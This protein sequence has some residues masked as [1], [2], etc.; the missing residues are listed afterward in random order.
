M[1]TNTANGLEA[2]ATAVITRATPNGTYSALFQVTA[3]YQLPT[4]YVDRAAP[5]LRSR[6]RFSLA[7]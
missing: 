5:R 2:A 3:D 4:V 6:G 7:V 1:G